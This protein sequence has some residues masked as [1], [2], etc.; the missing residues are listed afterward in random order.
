M[1]TFW[2]TQTL[3]SPGDIFQTSF[4]LPKGDERGLGLK[5]SCEK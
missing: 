1:M 4:G 5:E 3:E 2:S